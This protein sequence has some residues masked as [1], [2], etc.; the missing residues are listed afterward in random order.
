MSK[1]NRANYVVICAPRE[2]ILIKDVGPHD[3]FLT[4][5][6]G[7]EFVIQEMWANGFLLERPRIFYVDTD[8][9]VDE[10]RYSMDGTQPRFTGYS[11]IIQTDT[12]GQSAKKAYADLKKI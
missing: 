7:A 1:T 10:L 8:E 12:I 9:V 2:F 4:V 6:N 3:Q 11:T 5:T